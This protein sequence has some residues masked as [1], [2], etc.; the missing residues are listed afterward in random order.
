MTKCEPAER[1]T[2]AGEALCLAATDLAKRK[3]TLFAVETAGWRR[4]QVEAHL[5]AY[6]TAIEGGVRAAA[7]KRA[8]DPTTAITAGLDAFDAAVAKLDGSI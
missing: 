2:V 7:L 1:P 3:A 5:R 8:I 4:S 6:R